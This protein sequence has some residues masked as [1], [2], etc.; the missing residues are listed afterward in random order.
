MKISSLF[1]PLSFLPALL[2]MYMI[3]SF[4]AETGSASSS[5][6][7]KVSE[8]VV[9][10]YNQVTR[11]GWDS[12]QIGEKAQ[13]IQFYIRKTA[14][15][16]EYFLLA[17]AVSF[18]LYVYGVRGLLLMV[19]AGIICVGYACGDE[20]HQ[21]LVA[22]RAAQARDVG[23]DS[24]G[25]LAGVLLVRILGWSARVSVTGPRLERRQRRRQE[26]LDQREEELDRRERMLEREQALARR[27]SSVGGGLDEA[28]GGR[29]QAP[30]ERGYRGFDETGT[31]EFRTDP[32][33]ESRWDPYDEEGS[34][35][36][37]VSDQLSGDIP[38]FRRRRR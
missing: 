25:S 23:I 13:K 11:Q 26:E 28:G 17:V 6:S 9:S 15:M 32:G 10:T 12:W 4:S 19:L 8:Q 22:G 14:H 18:P 38:F 1:K 3:Y 7:Y 31:G 24:I 5:T 16:T 20:Y 30:Y 33:R 34:E 2:I 35:D 37:D 21:S 27:R 29:D 36:E